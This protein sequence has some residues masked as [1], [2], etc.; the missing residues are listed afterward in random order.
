VCD[1]LGGCED[2][3]EE[4]SDPSDDEDEED[5]ED[6]E[7]KDEPGPSTCGPEPVV[8]TDSD[9]PNGESSSG[10]SGPSESARV[11]HTET[12]RRR[13]INLDRGSHGYWEGQG[14]DF[15]D[16]PGTVESENWGCP[17]S[18]MSCLL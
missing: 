14:H 7:S 8:I 2:D 5:E 1:T 4:D 18:H 17:V 9:P 12:R 15:G 6:E 11:T 3:D 13:S 10:E 16:E